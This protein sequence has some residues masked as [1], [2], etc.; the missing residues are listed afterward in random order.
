MASRASKPP[1]VTLLVS[2]D[3]NDPTSIMR[4]IPGAFNCHLRRS[5]IRM[6]GVC[7]ASNGVLAD[8]SSNCS[9][10]SLKTDKILKT[11]MCW[12]RHCAMPKD[13]TVQQI[14]AHQERR[15]CRAPQETFASAIFDRTVS[16]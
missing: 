9:R 14:F 10:E 4:Q 8:P 13:P 1:Y 16:G 3:W 15:S 7:I 6:Q 12:C 11:G 5:K 2:P